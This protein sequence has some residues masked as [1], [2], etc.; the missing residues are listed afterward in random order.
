MIKERT[1]LG[2]EE[3]DGECVMEWGGEEYREM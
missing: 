3:D 1:C 2:A